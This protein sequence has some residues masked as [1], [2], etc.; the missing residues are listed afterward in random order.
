MSVSWEQKAQETFDKV[1]GNLPEFHRTIAKRLVKDSA[2]ALAAGRGGSCV[3]ERDL[4]TAFFK[5]IPP[6]FKDMMIR[7]FDRLKINYA[8]YINE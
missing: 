1:I 3:E 8:Q 5:E 4:I 7:L 2:E 6:A